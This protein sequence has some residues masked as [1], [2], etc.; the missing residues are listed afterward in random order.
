MSERVKERRRRQLVERAERLLRHGIRKRDIPEVT[1][2]IRCISH[3]GLL[4]EA[5]VDGLLTQL[6][7]Q[8]PEQVFQELLVENLNYVERLALHGL[9]EDAEEWFKVFFLC[10]EFE[11]MKDFV[12]DSKNLELR[13]LDI[14]TTWYGSNRKQRG[15]FRSTHSHLDSRD[16]SARVAIPRNW[17]REV[18]T[19]AREAKLSK[20]GDT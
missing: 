18:E 1:T 9:P 17:F 11:S 12:S 6:Q 13:L 7:N 14:L 15:L 19:R 5:S 10:D 2:S 16:R 4:D 8:V 20:R 3:N